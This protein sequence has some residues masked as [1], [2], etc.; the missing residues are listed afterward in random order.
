M[1]ISL[2][3]WKTLHGRKGRP[4]AKAPRVA[5]PKSRKPVAMVR[6]SWKNG[7]GFYEVEVPIR[8]LSKNQTGGGYESGFA[9]D[10]RHKRERAHVGYVLG[11]RSRWAH[12]GPV[13]V[14][15]TRLAPRLLDDDNPDCKSPRDQVAKWLGVN[16]G[17]KSKVVFV[18]AQKK[19]DLY[20]CR[21]RIEA[22]S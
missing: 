8:I 7:D 1:R 16:D 13:L 22:R 17:D 18:V 19:S 5:K 3:Q 10:A 6:A 4:V 12:A 15:I 11:L 21:I 2:E 14:T 9:R 20:G